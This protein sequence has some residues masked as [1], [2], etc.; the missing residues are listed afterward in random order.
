MDEG[1]RQKVLGSFSV[2]WYNGGVIENQ[3]QDI[4]KKGDMERQNNE[5]QLEFQ[6][7]KGEL[8]EYWLF[9]NVFS[10]TG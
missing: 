9:L 2:K 8:A 10:R 4:G 5:I 3:G 1:L 7:T 6:M